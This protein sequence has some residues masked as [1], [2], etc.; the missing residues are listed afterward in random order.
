MTSND[1]QRGSSPWN[2]PTA[3]RRAIGGPDEDA[4][5]DSFQVDDEAHVRTLLALTHDERA[6]LLARQPRPSYLGGHFA[7]ALAQLAHDWMRR[8]DRAREALIVYDALLGFDRNQKQVYANAL[9]AI[10]D[11]NTHLGIDPARARR[12]VAACVAHGPENPAIF[13][14]A[15]CVLAELG[16]AEGSLANV[17]AAIDA[18][19]ENRALMRKEITEDPLFAF[20]RED[21]R[22][23]AAL[24][25]PGPQGAALVDRVIA[26]VRADGWEA[27]SIE[28]RSVDDTWPAHPHDVRPLDPAVLATLTLPSGAAL[29]PSLAAWLAFDAGWLER[30]GWFTTRPHFA[31]TPRSLGQLACDEYGGTLDGPAASDEDADSAEEMSWGREFDVAR[32]DRTFLLPGGSDSRRVYA[33][34]GAPDALGEYP[35]LWTDIDDAPSLGVMFPGFDVWLAVEAGLINVSGE[36]YGAAADD[37]RYRGRCLHHARVSFDGAL[38]VEFPA[39]DFVASVLAM[40]EAGRNVMLLAD[41]DWRARFE[42]LRMGLTDESQRR[43]PLRGATPA[44]LDALAKRLGA[45]LPDAVARFYRQVNGLDW[46]AAR[47]FSI[48]EMLDTS[49]QSQLRKSMNAEEGELEEDQLFF[50][51]S[52]D[53]DVGAILGAWEGVSYV[54][55]VDAGTVVFASPSRVIESIL[56]VSEDDED[57]DDEDDDDD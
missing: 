38:D 6:S 7:R 52:R 17:R 43:A 51:A 49:L 44:E 54:A 10:Q 57:G 26:R 29:P 41:D 11:C 30:M 19:Y 47:F 9:W 42:A 40:R 22:F 37:F 53:N 20:V 39:M 8:A 27:L 48:A 23:L 35:V 36:T 1:K 14:N 24:D 12:F 15:A 31:W 4:L 46:R 25:D 33:L 21:R 18:G 13:Y 34:T 55:E 2:D 50:Y 28:P 32:F 16:D 56:N 3:A 45:P 5:R